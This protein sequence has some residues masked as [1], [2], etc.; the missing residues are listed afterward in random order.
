MQRM[1]RLRQYTISCYL[2]IARQ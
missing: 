1:H 2:F